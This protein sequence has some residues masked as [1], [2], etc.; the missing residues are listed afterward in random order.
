MFPV[1]ALIGLICIGLIW[2]LIARSRGHRITLVELAGA[3]G[4]ITVISL[5]IAYIPDLLVWLG[6]ISKDQ[7]N[8]YGLLTLPFACGCLPVGAVI[9]IILSILAAVQKRP[10][11][12]PE[13]ERQN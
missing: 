2:F 5:I 1:F 11:E 13:E 8:A 6:L 12:L 3:C 7:A 4:A 10:N 9:T